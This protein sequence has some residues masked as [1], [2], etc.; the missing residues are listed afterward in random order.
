MEKKKDKNKVT[1]EI[2]N[3]KQNTN[4]NTSEDN[5]EKNSKPIEELEEAHFEKPNKESELGKLKKEITRLT[6]ENKKLSEIRNN[7]V[8]ELITSKLLSNTNN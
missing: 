7:L 3:N 2:D 4:A 6:D 1:S 5:V 8:L